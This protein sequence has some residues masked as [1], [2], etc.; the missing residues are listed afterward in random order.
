M[1]QEWETSQ[2]EADI[3]DNDWQFVSKESEMPDIAD[4]SG[5]VKVET[6]DPELDELMEAD[7][8]RDSDSNTTVVDKSSFPTCTSTSRSQSVPHSNIS[9]SHIDLLYQATPD[10]LIC[11]MC[12]SVFQ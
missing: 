5:V 3:S 1:S 8:G 11:R 6:E 7:D 4:G 2:G 9:I 10:K 12:L